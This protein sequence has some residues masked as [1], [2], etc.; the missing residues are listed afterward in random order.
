[1]FGEADLVHILWVGFV[2]IDSLGSVG[3]FGWRWDFGTTRGDSGRHLGLIRGLVL[4]TH[5][6]S[7]ISSDWR[8]SLEAAELCR[9][10]HLGWLGNRGFWSVVRVEIIVGRIIVLL[11]MQSE[12]VHKS[13]VSSLRS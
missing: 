5:C 11:L 2:A 1:M 4:A 13:S 6:T 9:S 3:V 10:V 8:G 7:R 12:A